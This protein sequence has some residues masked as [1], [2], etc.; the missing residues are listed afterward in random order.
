MR[1]LSRRHDK[2]SRNILHPG[3]HDGNSRR[4]VRFNTGQDEKAVLQ[5]GLKGL[6]CPWRLFVLR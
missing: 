1:D 4:P 2:K 6:F 3:S 5:Q